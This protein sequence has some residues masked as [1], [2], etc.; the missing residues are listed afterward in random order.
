M[1]RDQLEKYVDGEHE[2]ATQ[3]LAICRA[4]VRLPDETPSRHL[5]RFL[6]NL[7]SG[8]YPDLQDQSNDNPLERRKGLT[9]STIHAAKGLQ[10]PVVWVMDATDGIIPGS[11]NPD[12]P[13]GAAEEERIFYVASTRA[14]DRLY[15]C[16]A[17]GG[18][19]GVE[20]KPSRYLE[21][22][23]EFIESRSTLD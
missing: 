13:N 1:D 18:G 2:G 16:H 8:A 7:K 21:I 17:D 4:S 9:L 11:V 20:A 3:I 5:C 22:L 12:D 6:E 15:Y 19:R 23:A 14:V 10:W